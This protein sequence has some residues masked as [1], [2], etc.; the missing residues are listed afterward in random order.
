VEPKTVE[1][2]IKKQQIGRPLARTHQSEHIFD[3]D[4]PA[5]PEYQIENK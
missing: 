2:F 5:K 1:K 3:F 4:K